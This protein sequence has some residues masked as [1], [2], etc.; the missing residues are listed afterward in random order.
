LISSSN[1]RD[2]SHLLLKPYPYCS[3]Y[4]LKRKWH[5]SL[6]EDPISFLRWSEPI[7]WG[8]PD[9]LLSGCLP[10]SSLLRYADVSRPDCPSMSW[11][12]EGWW[13]CENHPQ[14]ERFQWSAVFERR[15]VTKRDFNDALYSFFQKQST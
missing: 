10:R 8:E 2:L 6:W 11:R 13:M 4:H 14:S 1:L 3:P 7:F 5:L 9:R 12:F 15:R